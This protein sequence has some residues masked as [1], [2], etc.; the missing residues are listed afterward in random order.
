MGRVLGLLGVCVCI[1]VQG[2]KIGFI[3]GFFSGGDSQ[4]GGPRRGAVL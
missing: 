4:A 3:S 2:C 1:C